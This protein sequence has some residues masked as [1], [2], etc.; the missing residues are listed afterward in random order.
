MCHGVKNDD[1]DGLHGGVDHR[2]VPGQS[3]WALER[4]IDFL[5][6]SAGQAKGSITWRQFQ[7]SANKMNQLVSKRP[8]RDLTAAS[9]ISGC[10]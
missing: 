7:G 3:D 4:A 2:L 8:I 10:H 9:M 6:K 5:A 1:S